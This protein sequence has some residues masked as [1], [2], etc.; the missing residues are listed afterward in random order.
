M[1]YTLFDFIFRLIASWTR[2]YVVTD[3]RPSS[4]QLG[5]QLIEAGDKLRDLRSRPDA[6]RG[7]KYADELRTTTRLVNA[8][9]AEF[10]ATRTVEAH[11][12]QQAAWDAAVRQLSDNEGRGPTAANQD[13]RDRRPQSIG[14]RVTGSEEYRAWVEGGSRG[15]MPQIEIRALVDSDTTSNTDGNAGMLI[16][17]GAP[18]LPTPRQMKL[19]V[20]D[21]LPQGTTN[22]NN[23]NYVREYTPATDETGA[24]SVAEAAAK[25]EVVIEFTDADAPVR[26]IAAW[27]PATMEILSDAPTLRGYIDARLAY[28]VRFREQAEL[29]KG[30]GLAP[31]LEGLYTVSGT[32]TQTATNNDV[33]A[34]VA[35]SIAKVELVDGDADGIVMNPGDFWAS[36]SE[37]RSTTFDGEAH[38][39][40]G[41]PIGAPAPTLW[42]MPVVRTRALSSLECVVGD[43]S[44]GAMIFDREGITVRQSD[45]HDTYFIYNKVAIL[46]E[47]R[48]AFP[49]FRPDLFV[50]TTLDITA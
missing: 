19:V 44:Q 29:L 26:K 42:G 17:Q 16:P 50:L 45:S 14:Q 28:M 38:P 21:L 31:D 22:L 7:E 43:F 2:F 34:T 48:L 11:E 5:A 15:D 41:A 12:V 46:A 37:R 25:P 40:S 18:I 30:N 36:V 35:D 39:V 9:D 8:L 47:E 3:E 49:I 13:H 4:T 10:S 27:L 33:P 24:S 1:R 20:R 32:Q 23:I 6:E